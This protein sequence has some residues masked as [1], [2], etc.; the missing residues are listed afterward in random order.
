M[1]RFPLPD[2]EK[3]SLLACAE[4]FSGRAE[5]ERYLYDC[6]ERHQQVLCW[7]ER[8]QER[9]ASSVLELGANPYYLTLLIRKHLALQLTLANF[10]GD[11]LWNDRRHTQRLTYEG[12]SVELVFDHFNLETDRFPYADRS[13]D[14]VL[15]CEILEHLLLAPDFALAEIRRVLRPGGH[16]V[17]T[18]PNATRLASLIALAK[19]RSIF[20]GYSPHGPYGRHNR[21]YS[22]AEVLDLVSRAGLTVVGRDVRNI[23]P[24]PW[25]SRLIQSLRPNVW[26]EH[27]FVLARLD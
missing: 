12:Q 13:F 22:L 8:L 10:F 17:L 9:G 25:R 4:L 23:Y 18:T 2:S 26:R 7:L 11:R 16:L 6:W 19:G 1:S 27:L 14:V 21:E 15:F 20:P 3:E 24:H 5:A